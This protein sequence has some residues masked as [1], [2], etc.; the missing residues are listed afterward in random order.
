[1]K[2]TKVLV[3]VAGS[4][5]VALAQ[6]SNDAPPM[7]ENHALSES[8][9]NV[10][11]DFTHHQIMDMVKAFE[12]NPSTDAISEEVKVA[13]VEALEMVPSSEISDMDDGEGR[14]LRSSN[15]H[16]AFQNSIVQEAWDSAKSGYPSSKTITKS[17]VGGTD[18]IKVE[19]K[20][21]KCFVTAQES[22][23]LADW[24]N[25]FDGGWQKVETTPASER[26]CSRR[27]WVR[28]SWWRWSYE[29]TKYS[30]RLSARYVG[31]GWDG[32]VKPANDMRQQ[33]KDKINSVCGNRNNMVYV[34][35]SR[36]GGIISVV[37]L[38]HLK[39][40]FVR[41]SNAKFVS[42][43]SP[44]A[45]YTPDGD[46]VNQQVSESHRVVNNGDPVA[47]VPAGWWGYQ[48]VGNNRYG[49]D[50]NGPTFLLS[51]NFAAHTQYDA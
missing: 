18:R 51:Y 20:N 45:L 8:S 26:Y 41:G 47:T 28:K 12:D 21:G 42:F 2:I 23:D 6:A 25:N 3:A 27:G 13:L 46:Y 49:L 19:K 44:R 24:F 29:C 33:V 34:G 9:M 48:H 16:G 31:W 5:V 11:S 43:G 38:E 32:F 30:T 39:S 35:Y 22:N 37:L 7:L 17:Y 14:R 50:Y 4:A 15:V 1:M 10:L 40:G 36:G